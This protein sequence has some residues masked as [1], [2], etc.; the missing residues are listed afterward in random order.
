M[1]T[2]SFIKSLKFRDKLL[3]VLLVIM[4]IILTPYLFIKHK[5]SINS[6]PTLSEI[7]TFVLPIK[8]FDDESITSGSYYGDDS[9]GNMIFSSA[10]I[11]EGYRSYP[12]T[13]I[14]LKDGYSTDKKNLPEIKTK[15]QI[16]KED[17]NVFVA[18]YYLE[19]LNEQI[20]KYGDMANRFLFKTYIVNLE[21]FDVDNDGLKETIVSLCGTGGN[22]CPHEIIIVKNNEIIFSASKGISGLNITKTNTGN[23]FYMQWTNSE[24]TA[25]GFCCPLGYMKTRFIFENGE[26]KPIYEQEIRYIKVND[27]NYN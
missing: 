12:T 18:D 24:L 4:L 8:Y 17:A 20:E 7:P 25:N 15:E 16:L 14:T 9:N 3:L 22:H 23:G 11:D 2:I 26:F 21:E 13:T 19:L 6:V 5:N 10:N 1:E 27:P